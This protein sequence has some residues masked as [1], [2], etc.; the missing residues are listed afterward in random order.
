MSD[1][2]AEV[3]DLLHA[4]WYS[5]WERCMSHF[6]DDA[7]Y[8][9]PLLPEPVRGKQGILDIYKYCHSWGTYRGEIRQVFCTDRLATAELRIRGKVTS[10]PAGMP[11]SVVGKEF[12]FAEADVFEFDSAGNVIRESIYADVY[13]FM[14]QM[15]Q[16]S[17][18]EQPQLGAMAGLLAGQAPA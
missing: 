7:L 6:A 17:G 14:Q 1:H 15:G 10:P 2:C 5:N 8:E 9:D 12:D 18:P 16:L 13:T 3:S 4:F 11:D